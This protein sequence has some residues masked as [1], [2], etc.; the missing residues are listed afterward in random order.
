VRCEYRWTIVILL[1]SWMLGGTDSRSVLM[2]APGNIV[3]VVSDDHSPDMGC[4][5]NPVVRT[6]HLDAL[7]AEG[8][9]FVNAF[10]TTASCSA[11]RSVIL[12][13][14]HNHANGQYGHQHHFHKF[15]SYDNLVSLPVYLAHAGYRTARCGKY[16]VAP[17]P[18]YQFETVIPGPTR[19]GYVMAENCRKFIGEESD[20][21]FFL[22]FCVSDPHRGGGV[23]KELPHQPDRFGNPAPGNS[24]P[25]IDEVVYDP[26]EVI[27][28]GFLPDTPSCR[29][30]L[31]QYYQ[32][33]SRIDQGVGRLIQV[34]KDEG[35]WD[36]TLLIYISDHGIA[37]PGAKTTLYDGGMHSPLLVR[38]PGGQ[39][40]G[41]VHHAMV[42]WVDLTP[43]ILDFAR[44]LD[45][46]TGRVTQEVLDR[47]PPN[48]TRT[49][50]QTTRDTDRG[51]MHGR[52]FLP[53]LDQPDA[54]G[55]DTVYASHT[56]HEI[57]MYYPMRVVRE[58]RWKLIWN[59]AHPLP[60]PF[61]SDL[62]AAPTWQAQWARGPDAPFGQKTVATYVH[63]PA[64]ELYDIQ[65]DP[66]EGNNLADDPQHAE[67]LERLKNRLKEFQRTTNDPWI[68]KWDYE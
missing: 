59:I 54:E 33:I 61:A 30:E 39:G 13:G 66:Y 43:T 28:H 17:E 3:L 23:A 9:R 44:V 52:S 55:W 45:A 57:Q 62:W 31:A 58:R 4:Y 67:Q 53:I 64:F 2:A 5:G 21:P 56:F 14:L 34:L 65:D 12:S 26:A 27:V 8:T 35:V 1:C 22:Y 63:R 60:F 15:S 6:P 41:V 32:S 47:I 51:D 24:Y 68:M 48:R 25:G 16:H 20:K 40:R 11:S 36:N 49:D 18:V 7:A 19:N 10:C 50:P 29:A 37:M 42:S 38:H 46:S